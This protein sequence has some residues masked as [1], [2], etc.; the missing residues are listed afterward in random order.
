MLRTSPA[1]SLIRLDPD[2]GERLSPERLEL[3]G[4]QL[5]VRV[6]A[7]ISAAW[8]PDQWSAFTDADGIGLLV[9]SGVIVRELCVHDAPSAE[10]FGPGDVIRARQSEQQPE[11]LPTAARWTALEPAAVA[12]LDSSCTV[13][14]RRFPEVMTVILDRFNA[15]AERLA[16]TQA[17]S[18]LTGVEVRVEALLWHL[19]ERWG[20]VGPEGMIVPIA[21]SHRLIGSLIGARRP[22]VSTAIARLAARRRLTRRPDGTWFLTGSRPPSANAPINHAFLADPDH[23]DPQLGASL[24][25]TLAA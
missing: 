9:V 13:A 10:L 11:L 18:Q 24:A 20:R 1:Q 4:R 19:A 21:L 23:H 15:R 2:L 12:L 22:T 6:V 7:P 17:I 3:A 8:S 14:L 25:R 5:W 16:V